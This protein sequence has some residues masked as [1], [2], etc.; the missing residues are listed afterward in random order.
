MTCTVALT[1][2]MASRLRPLRIAQLLVQLSFVCL[3]AAPVSA[4]GFQKWAGLMQ[5]DSDGKATKTI[6][7][8]LT[9][10][11]QAIPAPPFLEGLK[12][13]YRCRR[14]ET[15]CFKR[16]G[17]VEG[18]IV[19][20]A[21]DQLSLTA[22]IQFLDGGTCDLTGSVQRTVPPSVNWTASGIYSCHLVAG[23]TPSGVFEL[24]RKR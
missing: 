12:G 7:R 17:R 11:P 16:H 15:R 10:Q 9:F 14:I 13:R 22:T 21:P 23:Q 8:V 24:E 5:R 20:T 6:L 2:R 1:F 18:S 4:Q 19:E 3:F